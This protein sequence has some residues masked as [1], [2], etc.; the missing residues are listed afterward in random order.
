MN[1]DKRINKNAV[2]IFKPTM[3]NLIL[4]AT[5]V[6]FA[7]VSSLMAGSNQPTKPAAVK[8]T[9][10]CCDS[11]SSSDSKDCCSEKSTKSAKSA[12]SKGMPS[13]HVLMSPKAAVAAGKS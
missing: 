13:R 3:K 2:K 11:K 12:C 8:K 4:C 9:D 5:L 10:A 7:S 1:T 6:A